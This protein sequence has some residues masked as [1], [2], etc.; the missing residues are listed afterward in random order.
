M[1]DY[2]EL[3][4]K[5]Y[6]APSRGAHILYVLINISMIIV[7]ICSVISM[8]LTG[9]KVG[10][11]SGCIVSIV[12]SILFKKNKLDKGHYEFCIMT[13]SF[14]DLCI[15]VNYQ[16]TTNKQVV[17]HRNTIETLEYSDVLQCLRV[18]C[19]YQEIIESKTLEKNHSELLLYIPT[20][21]N[22]ELLKKI[23]SHSGTVI[24]FVDR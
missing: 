13:I 4:S 10:N 1:D 15:I 11:I 9:P 12:V 20:D 24:R 8:F 19:D 17:I 6:C 5:V 2:Y 7:I 18:L 14:S 23:E 22:I 16:A 3:K 21:D